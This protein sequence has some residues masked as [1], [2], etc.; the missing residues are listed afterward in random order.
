MSTV[1]FHSAVCSASMLAKH[2]E[3]AAS[4]LHIISPVLS[5]CVRKQVVSVF[6]RCAPAASRTTTRISL[7]FFLPQWGPMWRHTRSDSRSISIFARW[8]TIIVLWESGGSAK[9]YWTSQ[10]H[11]GNNCTPGYTGGGAWAGGI[12]PQVALRWVCDEVPAPLPA[13]W[14]QGKVFLLRIWGKLWS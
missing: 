8:I 14:R 1:I 4:D 7:P 2:L 5:A 3:A 9:A 12:V 10:R 6:A 13:H 11:Y